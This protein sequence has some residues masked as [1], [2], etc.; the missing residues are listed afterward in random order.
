MISQKC[1]TVGNGRAS[2]HLLSP[3]MRELWFGTHENII[4]PPYISFDNWGE[5]ARPMKRDMSSKS[6]GGSTASDAAEEYLRNNS[7]WH[8]VRDLANAT[9]YNKDYI[10]RVAKTLANNNPNAESRKNG[11]KQIIGYSINGN[12][13]VPGGNKTALINLI[14]KYGNSQPGNL[15]G[16]SVSELQ[17]YLRYNIANGIVPLGSKLEF[18]WK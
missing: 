13:E 11:R 9:G 1:S 7:G 14:K 10:R 17:K 16:M 3:E 4:G 2:A 8:E 12:L 6:S 18:R 5:S 15:Q